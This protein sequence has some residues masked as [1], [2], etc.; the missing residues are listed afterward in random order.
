MIDILE[1]KAA[2]DYDP[3][4]GVLRR[5]ATGLPCSSKPNTTTGYSRV[6]FKNR[7][8]L[9]HHII[10]AICTGEWPKC[11]IDH[12]NGV[13]TDNRFANLRECDISQNLMNSGPHSDNKT[14]L[15]G[16]SRNK[17]RW[18]ACIQAYGKRTYLG[19]FD[20]P[21]QAHSAYCAAVK[22]VHGEFARTCQQ[23]ARV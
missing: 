18:S 14:G 22:S 16:V 9:Q 17:K 23:S 15:K 8:F 12:V 6:S 7:I 2:F 13:K 19:T 21:E 11:R 20:A 1:I 4:T 10:W 5:I 3:D